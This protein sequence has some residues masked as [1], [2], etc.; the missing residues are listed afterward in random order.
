[1]NI[2]L[3]FHRRANEDY[4]NNM[5]IGCDVVRLKIKVIQPK[6]EVRFSLSAIIEM[7]AYV[8]GLSG[9]SA[10]VP[11]GCSLTR[12]KERHESTTNRSH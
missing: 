1:M 7:L 2:Y 3:Q 8:T 12:L 10:K 6:S 11:Q 9:F 5:W 4:E